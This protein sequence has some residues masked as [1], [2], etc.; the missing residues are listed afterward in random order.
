MVA[1]RLAE[2]LQRNVIFCRWLQCWGG[3]SRAGMLP[4][5]QMEPQGCRLAS[6]P[7]AGVCVWAGGAVGMVWSLEDS[8]VRFPEKITIKH[9][10]CVKIK[11]DVRRKW[12]ANQSGCY[13]LFMANTRNKKAN[14]QQPMGNLISFKFLIYSSLR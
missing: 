11:P 9:M 5:V 3:D 12:H 1:L 7:Q 6:S 13:I 14:I 10:S 4:L 8:V 2:A